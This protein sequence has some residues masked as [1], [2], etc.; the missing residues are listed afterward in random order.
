MASGKSKIVVNFF[1]F[2]F[3]VYMLKYK[4][5]YVLSTVI[6]QG[7]KRYFKAT[8]RFRMENYANTLNG[9]AKSFHKP[10]S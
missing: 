9:A 5:D 3:R 1:F 10:V 4:F 7:E 2:F 8:C 6:Q